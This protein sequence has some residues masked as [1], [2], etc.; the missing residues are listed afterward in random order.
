MRGRSGRRRSF[1]HVLKTFAKPVLGLEAT[2]PCSCAYVSHQHGC[3][4]GTSHL[5]VWSGLRQEV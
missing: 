1:P 4:P 3:G 5:L 2:S